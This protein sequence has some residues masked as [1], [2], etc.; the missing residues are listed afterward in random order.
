MV[1]KT[2]ESTDIDSAVTPAVGIAIVVAIAVVMASMTFVMIGDVA[3]PA[4]EA[5]SAGA[6]VTYLSES[7]INVQ[8]DNVQNADTVYV[9]SPMG[10]MYEL[11]EIGDEQNIL[12]MEDGETPALI[13]EK[14]GK[15]TVV[16]Q[17]QP[18]SFK[19]DKKVLKNKDEGYESLK[20]AVDDAVA[21]EIIAVKRDV[22]EVSNL[23]VP[24]A[25]TLIAEDGTVI[26][27]R[28][29]SDSTDAT[30][31][32]Q[33]DGAVVSNFEIET[34]EET[35][36]QTN[37]HDVYVNNVSAKTPDKSSTSKVEAVSGGYNE[38]KGGEA[39]PQETLES[40]IVV[41]DEKGGPGTLVK[42]V[43]ETKTE[44]KVQERERYVEERY[45]SGCSPDTH[46][47]YHTAGRGLVCAGGSVEWGTIYD[48]RTNTWW[49]DDKD[50]GDKVVDEKEV[51]I[52][53]EYK[54]RVRG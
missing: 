1:E 50:E 46:W 34:N 16:Q 2:D 17:I 35:G 32:V 6:N 20:S 33:S 30:I 28:D 44:Y 39:I 51:V 49:T 9:R 5:P 25:I 19:P 14:D 27:D 15:R 53:E 29:T 47:A 10:T 21:G 4:D 7:T 8:L 52:E 54:Y 48:T 36:V 18:H 40:H 38:S 41:R 42:K 22:Y 45:K 12:N 23:D 37:G 11:E 13:A 26:R 43:V 3:Q 24:T 31:D